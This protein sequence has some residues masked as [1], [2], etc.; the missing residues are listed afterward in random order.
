[1]ADTKDFKFSGDEE[2]DAQR[3]IY[4]GYDTEKAFNAAMEYA[5][6]YKGKMPTKKAKND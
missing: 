4:K 6:K 5:R 1:M 3:L 2:K